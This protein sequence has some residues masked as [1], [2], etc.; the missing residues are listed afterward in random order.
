[1]N[2]NKLVLIKWYDAKFCS[3]TLSKEDIL[4]KKMATFESVG[5]LV[6]RDKI[7][8]RIASE[9][10]DEGEYRD[11]TLMPTGSVIS[12]RELTPCSLV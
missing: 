3:G 9:Y 7:T 5:Y 12:M 10:N 4:G 2:N 11:I 8:T 6:A 1:M